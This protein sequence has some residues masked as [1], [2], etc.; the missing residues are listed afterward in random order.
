MIQSLGLVVELGNPAPGRS[1]SP[2][3]FLPPSW[4]WPKVFLPSLPLGHLST[5]S[6]AVFYNRTC[7]KKKKERQHSS[8]CRKGSL[9]THQLIRE[10]R[11]SGGLFTT[12]SYIWHLFWPK[13]EGFCFVLF[14]LSVEV[15]IVI[16]VGSRYAWGCLTCLQTKC[17]LT[18]GIFR[19]ALW[20]H[21]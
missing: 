20:L 7:E 21:V 16:A 1:S 9:F 6:T 4:P 10:R 19:Y 5:C 2:P 8:W 18:W 13:A 17:E 12:S 3:F 14:C 15:L 11:F